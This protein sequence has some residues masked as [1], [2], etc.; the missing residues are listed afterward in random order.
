MI[1]PYF[2]D[3]PIPCKIIFD[4]PVEY[5]FTNK[6]TGATESKM[7]LVWDFNPIER[8]LVTDS[9]GNKIVDKPHGNLKWNEN[10]NKNIIYFP[11]PVE[12]VEGGGYGYDIG[13]TE[14]NFSLTVEAASFAEFEIFRAL[15]K[16]NTGER[17]GVMIF[18][19]TWY[20]IIVRTSSAGG[21]AGGQPLN[22]N[23][24]ITIVGSLR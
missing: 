20:D 8:F 16:L 23:V 4:T 18:G 21:Q 22:Y 6:T 9:S 7:I 2:E 3:G 10:L 17:S 15:V 1:T 11:L 24:T 13:F 14:D 19:R 5:S 12:S